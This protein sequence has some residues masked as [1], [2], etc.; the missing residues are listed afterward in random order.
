M[1][2]SSPR[3]V[4]GPP[5]PAQ[6]PLPAGS[7]TARTGQRPPAPE[8]PGLVV[9]TRR[10][11]GAPVPAV[12]PP[13]PEWGRHVSE[14]PPPAPR[15]NAFLR[16]PLLREWSGGP[17]PAGLD[18]QPHRPKAGPPVRAP[19]PRGE[20]VVAPAQQPRDTSSTWRPQRP[21]PAPGAGACGGPPGLLGLG[22]AAHSLGRPVPQVSARGSQ[23]GQLAGA[24]PPGARPAHS[25]AH[26]PQ[27]E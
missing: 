11:P 3:R 22:P 14:L 24:H 27:K 26:L 13:R 6:G 19:P 4:P 10:L 21:R 17:G 9:P 15:P 5:G 18:A 7:P 16:S 8:E 20:V 23:G 1:N 12:T 25:R 2:I